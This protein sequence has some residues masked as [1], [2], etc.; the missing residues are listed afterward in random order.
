MLELLVLAAVKT[1]I[2]TLVG[3]DYVGLLH[4][5]LREEPKV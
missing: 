3:L 1:N 4:W 5:S 2:H